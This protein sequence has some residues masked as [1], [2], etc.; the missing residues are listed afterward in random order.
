[1]RNHDP[2]RGA[3][4]PNRAFKYVPGE[5]PK[6]GKIRDSVAAVDDNAIIPNAQPAIV[7]SISIKSDDPFIEKP[8]AL[9]Q[10][11]SVNDSPAWMS[12]ENTA[13]EDENYKL[14]PPRV[15]VS[16]F[17]S[18]EQSPA[19]SVR[20][21]PSSHFGATDAVEWAQAKQKGRSDGAYSSQ[22]SSTLVS[23]PYPPSAVGANYMP[24]QVP[25]ASVFPPHAWVQP[26]P[27]H[28]P[29]MP[30]MGYTG[31]PNFP[32]PVRP[33]SPSNS[34]SSSPSTVPQWGGPGIMFPVS[35]LANVII[36]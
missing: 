33:S 26:M 12:A 32:A 18:R 28:Y 11:A 31:Y 10:F 3:W 9:I 29:Y 2:T 6:A 5:S 20:S 15:H 13:Y 21:A 8:S 16:T 1:M 36:S 4:K 30:Y 25:G 17:P 7:Q 34:E 22:A 27:Q 24:Y 35:C 19:P 23:A 14:S